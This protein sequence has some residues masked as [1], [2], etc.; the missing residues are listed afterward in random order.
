LSPSDRLL[1]VET[2]GALLASNQAGFLPLLVEM[3]AENGEVCFPFSA[4]NRGKH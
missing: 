1:G 3:L 2:K 4:I